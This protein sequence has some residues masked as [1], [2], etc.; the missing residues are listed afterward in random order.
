MKF[1]KAGIVLLAALLL[2]TL[3][4]CGGNSPI[5]TEK[6]QKIAAEAAGLSQSQIEDI[7]THVIEENHVPCYNVHITTEDGEFSYNIDAVTGEILSSG[8]GGH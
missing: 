5:S 7:H 1:R 3:F 2:T 8:E 4:A 6:A